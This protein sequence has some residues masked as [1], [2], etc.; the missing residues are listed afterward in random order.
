MCDYVC[1][2]YAVF[3]V[4]FVVFVLLWFMCLLVGFGSK[5]AGL[6]PLK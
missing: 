4:L 5:S 1:M 6:N 3:I 2:I